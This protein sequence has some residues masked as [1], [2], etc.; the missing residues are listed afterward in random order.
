ME[1]LG[2]ERMNRTRMIQY[3]FVDELVESFE[4]IL[5]K[6]KYLELNEEKNIKR[7]K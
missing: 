4:Y 1:K 7:N 2:F 3:T 6:E 5:T